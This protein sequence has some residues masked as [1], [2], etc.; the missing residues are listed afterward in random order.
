MDD[1][2]DLDFFKYHIRRTLKGLQDDF[3]AAKTIKARIQIAEIIDKLLDSQR[4]LEYAKEFAKH[5]RLG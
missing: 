5:D 4:G 3:D 2:Q 1:N